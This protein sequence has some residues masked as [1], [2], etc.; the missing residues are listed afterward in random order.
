MPQGRD[1]YRNRGDLLRSHYSIYMAIFMD[2]GFFASNMDIQFISDNYLG[3]R[4]CS[5]LGEPGLGADLLND[6]RK[7]YQ[8]GSLNYLN[9]DN[10]YKEIED[11]SWLELVERGRIRADKVAEYLLG[12]YDE[13]TL[14]IEP[15]LN[16]M[17]ADILI[18]HQNYPTR[19]D[20]HANNE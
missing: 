20:W 6:S 12:K 13:I 16:L 3:Y 4:L 14:K 11:A 7:M 15:S 19:Y 17:V 1:F 10:G 5:A 8:Y 2:C 9:E 18:F